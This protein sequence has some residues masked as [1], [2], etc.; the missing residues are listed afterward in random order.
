MKEDKPRQGTETLVFHDVLLSMT[1]MK[2]INPARGQEHKED[3][4]QRK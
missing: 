4:N 3:V 2:E 1:V